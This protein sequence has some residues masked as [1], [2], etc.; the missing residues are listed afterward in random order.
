MVSCPFGIAREGQG[1]ATVG[2]TH[3]D[4]RKRSIYFQKGKATG[5]DLSQADGST[6]F[7]ARK[8][9]DLFQIEAGNERYETPEA[10][11]VGG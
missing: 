9:A 6:A 3:S 10:A 8:N 7:Q 5:A 4:G 11:V 1:T 2:V